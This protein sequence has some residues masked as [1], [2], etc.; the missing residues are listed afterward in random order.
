MIAASTLPAVTLTVPDA[1]RWHP[2]R[3]WLGALIAFL[4]AGALAATLVGALEQGRREILREK[5]SVLA[6]SHAHAV[7][8]Q[9]E[10]NMAVTYTLAAQVRQG[11]GRIRDF[12]SLVKELLPYYPGISSLQLL[13]DGII[14]QIVPLAGNEQAIGANVLANPARNKEALLA[15]DTGQL[16]LAGPYALVQ[17]GQGAIARLPVFLNDGDGKIFWGLV[18]VVMRF[19]DALVG[20]GLA[21]MPQDHGLSYELWRVGPETG[22]KQ[23]IA[24]SGAAALVDPVQATVDLALGN[25]TLSVSPV[26]GWGDP[27]GLALKA[28]LG[29]FF[30]LLMATLAKLLVES[31]AHELLLEGEVAARTTEILAT[32]R[33][34]QATLAAI[35]D[36]MFVLD[37]AGSIHEFHSARIDRLRLP[38]EKFVGRPISDYVIEIDRPAI[39]AG[40][41]QAR[42]SGHASGIQYRLA[43]SQG[44]LWYEASIAATRDSAD[45]AQRFIFLARDITEQ[46]HSGEELERH[47]DHLEELVTNRTTE[48]TRARLQA[49][50]ANVAKT[51]ILANMSHE[52][53]TPMNA[54]IGLSYVARQEAA[55][56]KQAD[57]LEQVEVAGRRLLAIISD[58]LDLSA[59]E[60]GQLALE[61]TDFEMSE[62]LDQ[63]ASAITGP[64]RARGLRVEV[65]RAAAP[66]WLCGDATR[67]RQALQNFAGNGVKFTEKGSIT[68]S[69]KLLED[70]GEN[71]LVRFEVADT[72]PG[73]AADQMSRLF[74]A[75]EQVDMSL[76]RRH[77]GN[78]LGLVITRRLA[79]LMGGEAGADSTVGVGSRFWFTAR[80]RRGQG[81]AP[82]ALIAEVANVEIRAAG[83]ASVAPAADPGR[84][85]PV[86]YEMEALL[87]RDDTAAR[88]LFEAH[89][90]LLL[91]ALGAQA[92]HLDRQL[93]AFDYPGALETVRELIRQAT[94]A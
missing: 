23:I 71:V 39:E 83:T 63:V 76:T 45:E 48:L 12:E 22:Q 21:A 75:F 56:A 84:A 60:A 30:S 68:L 2:S 10:R 90:P 7:R 37:A 57:L 64:A 25:W 86:L 34:L 1:S 40:L 62:L 77:G 87:S 91:A 5:V 73:I 79:Q 85:Q 58:I 4:A 46:K 11:H 8:Q 29:L 55:T 70:D 9:I 89:R 41:R 19:P 67:V 36:L 50:A 52:I 81:A 20:T 14:Q 66:L 44:I 13:P 59:I 16:T 31:R 51:A 32:Q 88:E 18:A 24:A 17:G 65:D 26:L 6:S 15:R 49:E 54:I 69:A 28:A 53:R 78:G 93:A 38:P 33:R 94:E 35:P 3:P 47:R 42:E 72:G 61:H 80:L 82:G 74:Q 43:L 92:M 27:L